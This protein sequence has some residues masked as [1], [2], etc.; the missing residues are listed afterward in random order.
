MTTKNN[1]TGDRISSKPPNQAYLDN[2]NE[3]FKAPRETNPKRG[4]NEEENEA[5]QASKKNTG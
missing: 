1:I 2:F 3:V 5:P 4:S